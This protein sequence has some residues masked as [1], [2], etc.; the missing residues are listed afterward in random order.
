VVKFP[1]QGTGKETRAFVFIDDFI[2]GL[3]CVIEKGTHLGIYHIGTMDEIT[4]EEV[5]VE[6]G[7]Y[8]R[9]DVVVVPGELRRGSTPRRCPDI[10][11][12]RELGYEPKTKFEDGLRITARWY[13]ENSVRG[14]GKKIL[15]EKKASPGQKT[16]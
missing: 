4:I 15:L 10:T 13:D 14:E 5:A 1:I 6:V 7:N 8:F 9:R 2:E 12:L 3:M 11:E 16:R